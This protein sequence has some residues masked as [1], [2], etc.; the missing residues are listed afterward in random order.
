MLGNTTLGM[1]LL[2]SLSGMSR[3]SPLS[4]QNW[5]LTS[6]L[7]STDLSFSFFCFHQTNDKYAC[8]STV[9]VCVCVCLCACV[10]VCVCVCLCVSECCVVCVFLKWMCLSVFVSTLGSHE[11]GHHKLLIT[12]GCSYIENSAKEYN[13]HTQMAKVRSISTKKSLN[14]RSQSYIKNK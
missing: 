6:S 4:S 11:M 13:T 5:K 12:T 9:S 10:H 1:T 8:V 3:H 7:P 14:I 2:L